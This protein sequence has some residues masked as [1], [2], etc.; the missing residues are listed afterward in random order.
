MSEILL[1]ETKE[2]VAILTINDAPYNRMS[3]DFMDQLEDMVNKIS[4]D[5]SIRAVVL[6]ASG[7]DNFSVGMNLKQLPEGVERKGSRDA[8]FDQRLS[9]IEKIENMNKPWIV[10]LFGYCLGGGLEI[11]L[12]CHFRLAASEDAQIGL[13]ELDLGAVPAWG[14]SARLAKCV[15]EHHAMDMI[16]RSKKISGKRALEIGLV[17]EVWPLENLKDAAIQLAKEL[18]NQPAK[19]V[20]SMMKV[21]VNSSD[22]SL[23]ELIEEERQAVKDNSG[24]KDSLEGMTAFLEKRKPIFNQD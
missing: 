16:L 13:P 3:L 22:R 12:G 2:A 10:T 1:Y 9:V 11:P 6:T 7:L 15:G 18:A 5:S 20:A 24:T 19:A 8:L 23:K 21:L 17:H 14:G 4:V